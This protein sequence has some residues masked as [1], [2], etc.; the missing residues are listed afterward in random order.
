MLAYLV[1]R[2][3]AVVNSMTYSIC[4]LLKYRNTF[5]LYKHIVACFLWVFNV[6]TGVALF[7]PFAILCFV[8]FVIVW[9]W[10]LIFMYFFQYLV[11]YVSLVLLCSPSM[12]FYVLFVIVWLSWL[13]FMY[14]FQYLVFYVSTGVALFTQY[15]ILCFICD[16]LDLIYVILSLFGILLFTGDVWFMRSEIFVVFPLSGIFR[17]WC[18]I[19]P[20]CEIL[21]LGP[22]I[23]ISVLV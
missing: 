10:W 16:C 3:N 7:I 11:F 15:V 23:Q 1:F 6:S 18:F 13:I 12:W 2:L 17:Y 4:H 21:F 9:L 14:F 20:D 5:Y 22:S 8:L 19:P